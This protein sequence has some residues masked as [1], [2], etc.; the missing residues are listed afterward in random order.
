MTEEEEV[1]KLI[2]AKSKEKC[3][4]L[5]CPVIENNIKR[6]KKISKL[7]RL[8]E[9][10]QKE[11][12]ELKKQVRKVE[13]EA[14]KYFDICMGQTQ[15]IED[16]KQN[17]CTHNIDNECISKQK[18]RNKVEELKGNKDFDEDVYVEEYAVDILQELLEEE[19][20]E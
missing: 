8:I 15:E 3:T 18:I 1:L 12:E 13:F 20:N 16:L 9:K 4:M 19:N 5:N 14:Q 11:I 2:D 7:N 17:Q 6:Q 10:Q